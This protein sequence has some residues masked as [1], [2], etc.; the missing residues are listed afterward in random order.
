[1]VQGDARTN[2]IVYCRA[3]GGEYKL[4]KD[5]GHLQIAP[6]GAKGS[7]AALEP[8]PDDELIAR[9]VKESAKAA[10]LVL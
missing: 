5:G 10:R 8:K 6:T 2:D 4:E 3:C 7:A 1:V 9:L